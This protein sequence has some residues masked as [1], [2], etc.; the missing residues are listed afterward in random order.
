LRA[1][2]SRVAK[3]VGREGTLVVLGR[4]K[5]VTLEAQLLGQAFEREAGALLDHGR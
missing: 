1:D 2:F 5:V 3:A 4:G